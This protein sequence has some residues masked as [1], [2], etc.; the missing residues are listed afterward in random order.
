MYD[1]VTKTQKNK[2]KKIKKNTCACDATVMQQK[3]QKCTNKKKH[4]IR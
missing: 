2:K 3:L 1:Y 4:Q